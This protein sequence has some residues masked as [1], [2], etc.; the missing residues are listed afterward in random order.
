MAL[1]L[2]LYELYIVLLVLAGLALTE[3]MFYRIAGKW[4]FR[5]R[6]ELEILV[7]EHRRI[8]RSIGGKKDRRKLGKIRARA[9]TLSGSVRRFT[10]YR[11][12]MLIP[13]YVLFSVVFLV[14]GVAV[15]VEYCIPFFS[16]TYEGACVTTTGHIAVLSFLVGL[17]LVQDD[18][19]AVLMFKKARL[20]SRIRAG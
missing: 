4:F 15:P 2:L 3:Y 14:R 12:L 8:T 6:A 9:Y 7:E 13:V 18:L 17:P 10:L 5:A 1:T 19:I 16:F 11:V 20:W